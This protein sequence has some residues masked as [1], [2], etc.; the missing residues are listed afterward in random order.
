M[1]NAQSEEQ[2]RDAL[3]RDPRDF[4]AAFNLCSILQ[5]QERWQ[6]ALGIL[7]SISRDSNCPVYFL[8]I[9]GEIL[10]SQHKWSEAWNAIDELVR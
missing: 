1:R 9:R 8:V 3:I 10:A 7:E 2:C 5:A 4:A 6:D